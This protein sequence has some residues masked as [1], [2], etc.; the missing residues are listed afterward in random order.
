MC[1][2]SFWDPTL[3]LLQPESIYSEYGRWVNPQELEEQL[4][5]AAARRKRPLTGEELRAVKQR[6]AEWKEKKLRAWLST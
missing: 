4:Q 3:A 6:K 2:T 1:P 5:G